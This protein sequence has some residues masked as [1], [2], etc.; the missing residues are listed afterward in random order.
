MRI[1]QVITRADTVGG[2]QKHVFDISAQLIEDGCE[3]EILSSGEGEFR[4]LIEGSNISFIDLIDMKRDVSLFEDVKVILRLRRKFQVDRPDV[5]A[6]HSV[7]AGLLARLACFGLGLKVV[8]TAHGW[9]HIKSGS[10]LS[11]VIYIFLESILSRLCDV[12]V[13]VSS[14]DYLYAAS[15]IG[16][17]KEKL[18]LIPNG[19]K[20][21]EAKEVFSN[22]S[23]NVFNILSV[24]R[25]QPPKDFVTLINALERIK[26]LPWVFKFI[27]GGDDVDIVRALI[28]NAGLEEKVLIEGFQLDTSCYYQ[29]SDAV[30]LISNSE[31]LPM[32]LIEAMSFSKPIIASSVGGVPELI[33]NNWNGF[34]IEADDSD[35]LAAKLKELI[36]GGAKICDEMGRNSHSLYEEKYSFDKMITSLYLVYGIDNK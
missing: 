29:S 1:F 28:Q 9:S 24:V 12:V 4:E 30:V 11:K 27:G 14:S 19:V 18:V 15:V 35:Y 32:S 36:L 6:I 26:Y 5:V 22:K 25:F 8:F 20:R 31:G 21:A 34:L 10:R 3:V 33:T 23:D 2:A 7:K 13:C 17:S 16:I